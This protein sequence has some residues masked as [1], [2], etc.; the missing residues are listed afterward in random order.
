M[1]LHF[2]QSS[3]ESQFSSQKQREYNNYSD[4][5]LTTTDL[6][7]HMLESCKMVSKSYGIFKSKAAEQVGGSTIFFFSLREVCVSMCSIVSFE[8][9]VCIL[10]AYTWGAFEVVG[11]PVTRN[12]EKWEIYWSLIGLLQSNAYLIVL[13]WKTKNEGLDSQHW[14]IYTLS[15]PSILEGLILNHL[16]RRYYEALRMF[17]NHLMVLIWVQCCY[18]LV[19]L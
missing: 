19:N 15:H 10:W 11:L 16:H 13:V 4:I 6:E 12:L 5:V 7:A 1:L 2:V 14:I 8:L 17:D 18:L 3:N 9:C